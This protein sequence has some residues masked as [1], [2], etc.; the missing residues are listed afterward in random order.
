MNFLSFIVKAF[1]LSNILH[2]FLRPLLSVTLLLSYCLCL[3]LSL[4]PFTFLRVLLSFPVICSFRIHVSFPSF[5]HPPCLP[6]SSLSLPCVRRPSA[7]GHKGVMTDG[8]TS[9]TVAVIPLG[10]FFSDRYCFC[11]ISGEIYS[12]SSFYSI[13]ILV[14][15]YF[16]LFVFFC[17]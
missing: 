15:D 17:L 14:Y 13:I 2:I 12:T 4:L 5:F 11:D 1:S 16:F 8:Q 10:L 7:A 3:S 9:P 6:I